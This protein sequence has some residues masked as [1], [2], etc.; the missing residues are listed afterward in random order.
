MCVLILLHTYVR[1]T[2]E[3][4]TVACHEGATTDFTT[5]LILLHMSGR[6][7][8]HELSQYLSAASSRGPIVLIIDALDQLSDTYDG[9]APLRQG[10]LR[11]SQP[12]GRA[13]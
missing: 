3:S 13:A 9:S 10:S 7:M 2:D 8:S 1:Q 11:A 5:V 4:R 12:E 6:R